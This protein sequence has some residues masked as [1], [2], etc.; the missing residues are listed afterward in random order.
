MKWRRELGAGCWFLDAGCWMLVSGFWV[1]DAGFWVLDAGK[2][3]ERM[4]TELFTGR[5]NWNHFTVKI[6]LSSKK[7]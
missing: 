4:I 7:F 2:G 3:K 6:F 1:L 5:V